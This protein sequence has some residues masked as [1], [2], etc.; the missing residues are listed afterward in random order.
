MLNNAKTLTCYTHLGTNLTVT[1]TLIS[2]KE[3]QQNTVSETS[4]PVGMCLKWGLRKKTEDR[5]GKALSQYWSSLEF[6]FT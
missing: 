4:Q 2:C 1:I 3:G 5:V 6:Y